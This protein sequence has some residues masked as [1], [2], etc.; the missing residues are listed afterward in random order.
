M[1][2]L[3]ENVATQVD[4]FVRRIESRLLSQSQNTNL[5]EA[6][7][8][9]RAVLANHIELHK[10]ELNRLIAE[11]R[12]VAERIDLVD[13]R[14]NALPAQIRDSFQREK[15]S[16][17]LRQ[18]LELDNARRE[19]ETLDSLKNRLETLIWSLSFRLRTLHRRHHQTS[20]AA[21]R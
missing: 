13:Q 18:A 21:E 4:E 3:L 1:P 5:A 6:E 16:Q 14:I 12:E 19:R 7:A 8:E 11:K 20:A 9:T 15:H 17:A 2:G 10:T